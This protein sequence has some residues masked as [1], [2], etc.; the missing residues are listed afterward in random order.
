MQLRRVGHCTRIFLSTEGTALRRIASKR[1]LASASGAGG[2]NQELHRGG[3]R[4]QRC[5]CA[6]PAR[7][8]EE[9]GTSLLFSHEKDVL[10][11]DLFSRKKLIPGLLGKRDE[12]FDCTLI[13]GDDA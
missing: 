3:A 6:G 1:R 12:I 4:D 5:S 9:R 8:A 7:A 13:G 2:Y 10:L 11:A